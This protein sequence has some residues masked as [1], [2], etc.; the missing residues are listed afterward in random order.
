VSGELHVLPNGVTVA[1][2]PLPGAESVAV[3]LYVSVGS[4]SEPERLGGL[5]H[6]VEHMVV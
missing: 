4:R 1:V 2:D 6:L 3:G 5:A